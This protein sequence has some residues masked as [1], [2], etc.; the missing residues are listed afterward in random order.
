MAS[1]ADAGEARGR[2]VGADR[3]GG[4][5][6]RR[7]AEDDRRD[8]GR[9]AEEPELKGHAQHL[10]L[11]EEEEPFRIAAHR[12]GLADAFGEAAV[13]GQRG[14]R[15][16]QRRHVEAGDDEAVAEP[17]QRAAGQRASH[18]ERQGQ[19][20]ILP[21]HAEQDGR[22]PQ[23]RADRQI[24]AAGDDDEGHGQGDESDLRH[25]AALVEQVVGG[26]EPVRQQGE[27]DQG[28]DGERRQNGL[29]AEERCGGHGDLRR[30]AM[31][32]STVARIMRPSTARSQ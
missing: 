29:V 31:S 5:A 16:D 8:D 2:L 11:A 27:H 7:H 18:G 28:E 25:Q 1:T 4:A 19:A 20:D 6:E 21:E 26:E 9:D 24:D 12:A 3:V 17:G 32:A 10:A 22:E 30:R 15:G 13:E 14:Q 23:N